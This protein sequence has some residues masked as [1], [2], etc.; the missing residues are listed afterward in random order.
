MKKTAVLLIFIIFLLSI[1]ANEDLGPI[2]INPSDYTSYSARSGV[3]SEL[4]DF[5]PENE[6]ISNMTTL[7]T[8]WFPEEEVNGTISLIQRHLFYDSQPNV[9]IHGLY[10][11]PAALPTIAIPAMILLHGGASTYRAMIPLAYYL[12]ETLGYGI[13]CLDAPGTNYTSVDGWGSTG[14]MDTPQ[15]RGNVTGPLGPRGSFIYYNVIATLRGITVLHS[16]PEINQSLIGLGGFSQGGIATIIANGVESKYQ[17]LK[18]AIDLAAAGN[19]NKD[20]F[21]NAG[22]SYFYDIEWGTEK[23]ELFLEAFDPINYAPLAYAPTLMVC[24]TNDEVFPL[25]LFKQ[26]FE[27][28]PEPKAF[29]LLPAQDHLVYQS[30]QN[31]ESVLTWCQVIVEEEAPYAVPSIEQVEHHS[32]SSMTIDVYQANEPRIDEVGLIHN[33]GWLDSPYGWITQRQAI[34]EGK[35]VYSWTIDTQNAEEYAFYPVVFHNGLQIFSAA[36]VFHSDMQKF[37]ESKSSEL[38][39]TALQVVIALVFISYIAV[40]KRK[41]RPS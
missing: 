26:T 41:T 4:P 20:L 36:P 30:F 13:L 28:L 23:S 33:F 8:E 6:F 25:M 24:G 32:N 37:N 29:S 11:R 17:R 19:W 35:T 38:T 21:E 15:F 18:F 14:P 9:R 39:A 3:S 7:N 12:A 1:T 27:K 10:I 31:L 2:K 34:Q 5:W 40:K 16:I 22:I